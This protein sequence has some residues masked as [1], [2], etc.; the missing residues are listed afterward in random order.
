VEIL[1]R[2]ELILDFVKWYRHHYAKNPCIINALDH[3]RTTINEYLEMLEIV[4]N[5]NDNSQLQI[6]FK[7]E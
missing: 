5:L 7:D 4:E 3:Q 2:K 1:N 6:D